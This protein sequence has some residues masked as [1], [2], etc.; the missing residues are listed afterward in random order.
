MGER[1]PCITSITSRFSPLENLA[2]KALVS[3]QTPPIYP[4]N[5]SRQVV[6]P[7]GKACSEMLSFPPTCLLSQRPRGFYREI[8]SLGPSWVEGG[9][10]ASSRLS[11]SQQQLKKLAIAPHSSIDK[12]PWV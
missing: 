7:P 10:R 8:I 11:T 4:Q 9:P 2:L 3:Q 5:P 12:H 6:G 1:E